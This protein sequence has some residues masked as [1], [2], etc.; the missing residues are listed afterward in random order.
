[1]KTA[2]EEL[3]RQLPGNVT[4]KWSQGERFVTALEH[5]SMRAELYAPVGSDPQTPHQQDELQFLRS[6][7]GDF[8]LGGERHRFGQDSAFF[9][10]AGAE[11]RFE[12][13]SP[14]FATWVVFWGP[15]GGEGPR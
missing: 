15:Q 2:V 11:H 10:A 8:V 14:D 12:N 9:I 4:E 3:L 13:F 1:M 5:G 6:G 7:S